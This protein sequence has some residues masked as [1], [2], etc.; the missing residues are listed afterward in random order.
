M[1]TQKSK[2]LPPREASLFFANIA[3]LLA[4][5]VQIDECAAIVADDMASLPC[6]K[7]VADICADLAE[8]RAAGLGDALRQSGAFSDY[9]VR[10]MDIAEKTGHQE[11]AAASLGEYYRSQYALRQSVKN[12]LASPLFMLGM[13]SAVLAFFTVFVMPVFERIFVSMGLSLAG[14]GSPAYWI[15]RVSLLAV[16]LL[17]IAVV[18]L[19]LLLN[20]R[21]AGKALQKGPLKSIYESVLLGRVTQAVSMLLGS[22]FSAEQTMEN[23]AL[24]AEMP[25]LQTK[26]KACRQ[27]VSE[28]EELSKALVAEGVLQ[29]FEAKLLLSAA[30]AGRLEKAMAQISAGYA[31]EADEK[32]NR[33][34][35][36]AE[37]LLVGILSLAVG[38]ALLS[39]LLPLAGIIALL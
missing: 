3:L 21:H 9:A 27:R 31:A 17:F 34:L 2:L 1:S 35:N 13:M 11:N 15:S 24:L 37:P 23:A 32:I 33:L 16:G 22:G 18:A 14:A 8:K 25:T 6:A 38:S 26:L 4:S 10:I 12:A 39:V 19:A 7:T 29:G 30:R 5:G 20:G 36:L 28:G